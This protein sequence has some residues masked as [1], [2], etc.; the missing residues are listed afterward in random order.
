MTNQNKIYHFIFIYKLISITLENYLSISFPFQELKIVMK[1]KY[2]YLS[3]F[4]SNF[5]SQRKD[6]IR[7]ILLDFSLSSILTTKKFFFQL[8]ERKILF[9]FIFLLLDFDSLVRLT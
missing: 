6:E 1:E 9:I 7:K 4:E 2:V 8:N 3:L 5:L